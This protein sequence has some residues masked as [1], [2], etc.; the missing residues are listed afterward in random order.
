[1]K[2]SLPNCLSSHVVLHLEVGDGALELTSL[3][4]GEV[5]GLHIV[6][7]LLVANVS[8]HALEL[9]AQLTVHEEACQVIGALDADVVALALLHIVVE[10]IEVAIAL[11]CHAPVNGAAEEELGDVVRE[12][13][14]AGLLLGSIEVEA[15][16]VVETRLLYRI[17]FARLH[18]GQ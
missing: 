14:R 10:G 18:L 5:E 16:G 3:L 1:M 4:E 12:E 11:E 2:S 8:F 7:L 9:V 13:Q 6:V 15:D 17:L